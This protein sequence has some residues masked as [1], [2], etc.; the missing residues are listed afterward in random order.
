MSDMGRNIPPGRSPSDFLFT[1]TILLN[2]KC[3]DNIN[4]G[5]GLGLGLGLRLES[6]LN[7]LGIKLAGFYV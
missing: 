3:A 5:L 7:R 2:L 1:N 6:D 4:I